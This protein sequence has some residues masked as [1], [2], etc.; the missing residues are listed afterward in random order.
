MTSGL[1]SESGTTDTAGSDVPMDVPD[2]LVLASVV[3]VACLALRL[4]A[5]DMID[6]VVELEALRVAVDD[7]EPEVLDNRDEL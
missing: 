7:T 6:S 5:E 3:L 4:A 1:L 2:K